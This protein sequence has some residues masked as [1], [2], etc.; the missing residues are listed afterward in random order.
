MYQ[1]A[2]DLLNTYWDGSLPVDPEKIAR[3]MGITVLREF[4]MNGCSGQV[5]FENNAPVIRYDI[6]EAPVRQRFTIAHEIGHV[7]LGHLGAGRT[8]FRDPPEHF[9]AGSHNPEERAANSFAADLLMPERIVRFAI[10]ERGV[11]DI[12]RL[13]NLF[14]VSQ[15]AMRYRLIN[16]GIL[17]NSHAY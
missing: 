9:S 15:A 16:L 4:G 14:A 11:Q 2:S 7:A 8:L 5:Q 1:T 12:A 3:S 10:Y 17:S 6:T 13:A